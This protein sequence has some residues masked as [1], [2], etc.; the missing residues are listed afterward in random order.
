[1]VQIGPLHL[2]GQQ[3]EVL[4]QQM[5]NFLYSKKPFLIH[6]YSLKQLSGD[7]H[8]PLHHLSAFINQHYGIHFNDY[9]NRF[10]VDHCIAKIANG[11]WR[12]KKLEAIAGESGFN[13]RN[14]F[15]V[16][17]KKVTGLSPSRYL[18]NIMKKE[19]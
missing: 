7:I 16:A 10:R 3:I 12:F 14:T 17:F 4:E 2:N 15:G 19:Q 9:I 11:E 13:N 5:N 6:G 18:K 8:I 1:M